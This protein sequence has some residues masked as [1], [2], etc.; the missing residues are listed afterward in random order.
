MI[1]LLVMF[2]ITFFGSL[3]NDILKFGIKRFYYYILTLLVVAN[4]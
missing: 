3:I 1:T 2:I 4:M